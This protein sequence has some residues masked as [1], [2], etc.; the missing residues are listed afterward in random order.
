MTGDKPTPLTTKARAKKPWP[1]VVGRQKSWNRVHK[2]WQSKFLAQ[3]RKIPYVTKAAEMSGVSRAVV[4]DKR[5]QSQEFRKKWDEALK[6]AIETLES[7]CYVR[8][9]YGVKRGIWMKGPGGVPVK[10]EDHVEFSD[11]LA[12]FLLR[13]HAPEKYRETV[14]SE[15]TT[16][17]GQPF[18]T[19]DVSAIPLLGKDRL[20]KLI[21]T[22]ENQNEISASTPEQ[23]TTPAEPVGP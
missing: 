1:G 15:I 12:E 21:A 17:A 8:A 5:N 9:T 23:A 10:V 14:R 16:P 11:R 19:Q 6:I 7:S 4:Y 13:A 2:G 18:Q 3:L 20:L 22:L